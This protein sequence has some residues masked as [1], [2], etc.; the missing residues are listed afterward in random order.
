MRR[1][2]K[3]LIYPTSDQRRELDIMLE[4]HRCL[5]NDALAQRRDAWQ[6]EQRSVSYGQQTG[7]DVSLA[8]R[9]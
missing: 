6:T 8:L 7:L 1:A 3:Y 9:N 2:Y 4:T 5:Y